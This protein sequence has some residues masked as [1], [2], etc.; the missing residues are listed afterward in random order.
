MF[1]R[2]LEK[3]NPHVPISFYTYPKKNIFSS[4]NAGYF[5]FILVKTRETEKKGFVSETL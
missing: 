5:S 1:L 3:I 4:E 2:L